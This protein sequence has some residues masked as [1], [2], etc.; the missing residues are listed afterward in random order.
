MPSRSYTNQFD[1]SYIEYAT[2]HVPS[3]VINDFKATEPWCNFG[4]IVPID[5]EEIPQCEAPTISYQGG[6][7]EFA[8]ITEGAQIHYEIG[9]IQASSGTTQ[10]GKVPVSTHITVTAYAT[11][12]GYSRSETVE[13]Q[14]PINPGLRGDINQDGK[15]TVADATEVA[16]I[17][18]EKKGE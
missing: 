2:L 10:G 9:G 8:C 17:I 14:L 13:Y 1:G 11:A 7:L 5:D 18:L 3:A 15:V 6:E 12:K 16:N 4:K